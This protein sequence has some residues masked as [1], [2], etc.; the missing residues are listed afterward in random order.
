MPS[1]PLNA[2]PSR[3]PFTPDDNVG[4]TPPDI[5]LTSL[6]TGLINS[7][8][9]LTQN[10]VWNTYIYKFTRALVKDLKEIF[11]LQHADG[12]FLCEM[13]SQK[14]NESIDIQFQDRCNE[15]ARGTHQTPHQFHDC[16][17]CDD[18]QCLEQYLKNVLQAAQL[19]HLEVISLPPYAYIGNPAK[20]SMSTPTRFF[21]VPGTQRHAVHYKVKIPGAHMEFPVICAHAPSS[22]AWERLTVNRKKQTLDSCLEQ[23]GAKLGG[24]HGAAPPMWMICGDLNT[25]LGVL[26]TWTSKYQSDKDPKEFGINIHE[27]LSGPTNKGGDFMLSQGFST[28]HVES[29]IGSSDL[30]RKHCSDNHN[31]VTL[32]GHRAQVS[33]A[34]APAPQRL[35]TTVP[36]PPAS[37][38]QCPPALSMQ[39]RIARKCRSSAGLEPTWIVNPSPVSSRTPAAP[40]GLSAGQILG[41]MDI[42]LATAIALGFPEWHTTGLGSKG[43]PWPEPDR[44]VLNFAEHSLRECARLDMNRGVHHPIGYGDLSDDKRNTEWVEW[45]VYLPMYRKHLRN[46]QDPI[47]DNNKGNAVEMINGLAYAALRNGENLPSDHKLHWPSEESRLAWSALWPH[48]TAMGVTVHREVPGKHGQPSRYELVVFDQ[49]SSIWPPSR[50]EPPLPTQ[51]SSS[52]ADSSTRVNPDR[53]SGDATPLVESLQRSDA[54]PLVEAPAER[55]SSST[56]SSTLIEQAQYEA[57]LSLSVFDG[58]LTAEHPVATSESAA[59]SHHVVE[60]HPMIPLLPLQTMNNPQLFQPEQEGCGAMDRGAAQSSTREDVDQQ[61]SDAI[62][63]VA[64]LPGVPLTHIQ[65]PGQAFPWSDSDHAAALLDK[66]RRDAA[67]MHPW[68]PVIPLQTMNNPQPEQEGCGARDRGAAQSNTREDIVQQNNDAIPLVAVPIGLPLTRIQRQ[69]QEEDIMMGRLTSLAESADDW[70]VDADNHSEDADNHSEDAVQ[71]DLLLQQLHKFNEQK[72]MA[73]LGLRKTIVARLALELAQASEYTPQEWTE[74]LAS[75]SLDPVQMNDAMRIWKDDLFEVG[76]EKK[77]RDRIATATRKLPRRDTRSAF[78]AWQ[79]ETYGDAG[80]AQ[81]FLKFP[82]TNLGEL[83]GQWQEYKKSDLYAEQQSRHAPR[84]QREQAEVS[85]QASADDSMLAVVAPCK[86]RGSVHY[87]GLQELRQQRKA[88]SKNTADPETMDWYLSGG[89]DARLE[90]MT[91]ENGTGRYYDSDGNEHYVYPHAFT[92][93]LEHGANR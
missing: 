45:L 84:N 82:H 75:V 61:N 9:M 19:Q 80:I 25:T 74:K 49:P 48:M 8:L 79:R 12:L 70:L 3:A 58:R 64:V 38:Q 54:T 89:L 33:L 59:S 2:A 91:R 55:A 87:N 72:R 88:V 62:P 90:E 34:L 69:E 93:W 40:V 43:E 36:A 57:I 66:R 76:M 39:Q 56:R 37:F 65:T 42:Q 6:N 21:T 15:K 67:E 24:V 27:A 31:L 60:S 77:T 4:A 18:S 20:V 16:A 83:L 68:H 17:F 29:T 85:P 51:S 13:G 50:S 35:P 10:G 78:R 14:S 81:V 11:G 71:A 73:L 26:Q 63:L 86:G 32:R 5:I 47:C 28:I 1:A 92:D 52:T 53:Q 46:H 22:A 7:H 23:A 44:R 41:Q 30:S